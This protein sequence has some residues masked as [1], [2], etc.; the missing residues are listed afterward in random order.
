MTRVLVRS[1]LAVV[2]VVAAGLIGWR[3]LRPAELLS[4]GAIPAAPALLEPGVTG[5]VASPPLLVAG[6]FRVFVGKRQVRADGPISLKTLYTPA[7]SF[8][9]WPEQ[10]SGV[11]ANGTTVVSRWS[12]GLLVAIDG[13]TGRELWRV[14]GPPAEGFRDARTTVWSPPGLWVDGAAVVVEGRALEISTGLSIGSVP[15]PERPAQGD[16]TVLGT[17]NGLRYLLTPDRFL[18]CEDERTGRERH[19]FRLA[20]GTEGTDWTPVAWQLSDGWLAIDR[21]EDFNRE[22]ILIAKVS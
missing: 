21:G 16:G 20:Y 8:R 1:L 10:L 6:R 17:A 3:V 13:L 19:R 15:A 11:V 5:R 14:G 4:P 18:V 9:R 2:L 7:W 22:H 12:D